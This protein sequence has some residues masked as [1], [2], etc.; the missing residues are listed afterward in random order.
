VCERHLGS[1]YFST[2]GVPLFQEIVNENTENRD[3]SLA[4]N[5]ANRTKNSIL[6]C[7]NC[8]V[9]HNLFHK[10]PRITSKKVSF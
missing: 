6:S 7:Y 10:S 8:Y 4:W 3:G 2:K 5:L 9:V 1:G